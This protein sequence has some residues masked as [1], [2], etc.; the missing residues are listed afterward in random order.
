M[1]SRSVDRREAA[2]E[3]GWGERILSQAGSR[4][5][6]GLTLMPFIMAASAPRLVVLPAL[7]P[8]FFIVSF[9]PWNIY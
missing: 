1:D 7:A 9:P 4:T 8:G 2:A 5:R 3:V 6:I